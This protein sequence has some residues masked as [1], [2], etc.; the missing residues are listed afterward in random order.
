MII[1]QVLRKRINFQGEFDELLRDVC[2]AYNIGSYVAFELIEMGYEDLNLKLTTTKGNYFVKI[3]AEKR[4]DAECLRLINIV[5]TAIDN[6]VNHP[7]FLEKETGFIF[8]GRYE[9]FN[10]RLAV[11]EYIAGKSFFE[12]KKNPTTEELKKII[13]MAAILNK[14]DYKPA[15]LY[16]SWALLNLPTEYKKAQKYIEEKYKK[17]L[18]SLVMKF[19]KIDLKSLPHALVHGDLIRSN[20]MKSKDKI[21]FVDLSVANYYPRVVELAVIMSDVMF[22]PSSKASIEKNY[23]FLLQEYQKHMKLTKEELDVL[24]LFIQMAHGMHI[25]GAT[26]EKEKRKNKSSENEHWLELGKKGLEQTYKVWK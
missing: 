16:D 14:I 18:D 11:F 19:E 22:D 5:K 21:Y 12:L 10:I 7:L 24:P 23:K 1:P 6:G 3:F 8:R 20:I 26:L 25:I 15:D 13:K 9:D 17:I 2:V 4:E